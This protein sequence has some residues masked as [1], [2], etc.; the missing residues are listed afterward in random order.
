MFFPWVKF[1]GHSLRQG[2]FPQ[3][4]PY[5]LGGVPVSRLYPD[6][7]ELADILLVAATEMV[8]AED[9]DRLEQGLREA[10]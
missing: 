6:R 3:W 8:T 1:L 4:N 7:S 5:L 2:A 9:M 10:L